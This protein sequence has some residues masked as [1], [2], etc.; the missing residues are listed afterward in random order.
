MCSLQKLNHNYYF[1]MR[2]SEKE[3][4]TVNIS[5]SIIGIYHKNNNTKR[6]IIKKNGDLNS[7]CYYCLINL[8]N[9]TRT[10]NKVNIMLRLTLIAPK[11]QSY[12][13]KMCQYNS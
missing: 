10:Y 8:N 5:E 9:S 3:T 2:Y 11:S 7:V 1:S 13:T 6:K 12:Y 4:L